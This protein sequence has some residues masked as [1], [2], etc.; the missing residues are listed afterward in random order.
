MQQKLESAKAAL[1]EAQL[2][3]AGKITA[4]ESGQADA[5]SAAIARAIAKRAAKA[6]ADT[7]E[8]KLA[9]LEARLA[10]A[11]E[12]L[13]LAEAEGSEHIDAFTQSVTK[14][15]QKLQQAQQASD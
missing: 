14:M 2:A 8:Q 15:E 4:T 10:A 1:P 7:A 11:R 9:K 13:A 6:P 3:P 5:A 12:K